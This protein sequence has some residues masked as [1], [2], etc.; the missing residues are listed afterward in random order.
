MSSRS[1]SSG[2]RILEGKLAIV[3]GGSRG[4]GAAT[5]ANLAAKGANLVIN[6]TSDSSASG[7][8]FR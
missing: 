1:A 6:Y 3:T 5:C 4:I 7:W 2:P 8:L